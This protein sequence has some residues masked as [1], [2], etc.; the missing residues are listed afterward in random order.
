MRPVENILA[1]HL[2][3]KFYFTL[4]DGNKNVEQS[5]EFAK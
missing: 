3:Q 2:P 5:L 4:G 1:S